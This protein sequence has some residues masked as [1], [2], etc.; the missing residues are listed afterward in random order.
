MAT[1]STPEQQAFF[2]QQYHMEKRDE[3]VG[4]LLAFF[5]GSFGAH[6]FYLHRSGLGILY[7]CFSWTGVPGLIGV[8]EALFMPQRVRAYNL[9]L[10]S[11]IA[12]SIGIPPPVWAPYAPQPFVGGIC[13]RCGVGLA[14]GARFCSGCGSPA[15]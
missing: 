3:V 13:T 11:A 6:H 12:G 8:V 9:G 4:V 5:L 10:A 14:P 15:D 7:I 2:Y 1:L